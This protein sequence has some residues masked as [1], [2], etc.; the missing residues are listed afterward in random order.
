MD[1]VG[2]G[3][4]HHSTMGCTNGNVGQHRSALLLPM[5]V[6]A[7]GFF[8]IEQLYYRV[9]PSIIDSYLHNNVS[10]I[11]KPTVRLPHPP[12]SIE[13]L[14]FGS[15]AII[16]SLPQRELAHQ[17]CLELAQLTSETPLGGE[18]SATKTPTEASTR[19][20]TAPANQ[21]HR[22]V[23]PTPAMVTGRMDAHAY[24]GVPASTLRVHS[25]KHVCVPP[26][27]DPCIPL[28]QLLPKP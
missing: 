20:A 22:S 14:R 26:H 2:R 27:R 9:L 18:H 7:G 8:I 23:P 25:C 15:P 3:F 10:L 19:Q 16:E 17:C 11:Q 4:Q 12:S 24:A 5:H 6:R 21:P 13:H 1:T 28:L